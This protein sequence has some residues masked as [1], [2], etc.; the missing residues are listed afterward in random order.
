MGWF[1]NML[2]KWLGI[3]PA[4]D[5]AINLQKGTTFQQNVMRNRLWYI[6][7]PNLLSQFFKGITENTN[8]SRFWAVVPDNENEIR[9]I[10]SDIPQKAID[11]LADIVLGDLEEIQVSDNEA[12]LANSADGEARIRWD[13]IADANNFDTT[14][15]ES[16]VDILSLG[17]GAFKFIADSAFSD[18][19]IIEWIPG[20]RVDYFYKYKQLQEI[21]FFT[22]YKKGKDAY[23]LTEK[24]GKG[25]IRYELKNETNG[26]IVPLGTIAE[27]AGLADVTFLVPEIFSVAVKFKNSK[28]YTGRGAGLFDGKSDL[29]DA[30]DESLSQ[31]IDALRAGRTTQYIPQ[32]LLTPGMTPNP[33]KRRWVTVEDRLNETA[34]NV[35]Q[36]ES[37]DIKAQDYLTTHISYLDNCLQ[38]IIS[39][40]TLGIDVKKLDNAEAQREKEKTTLYMRNKI[41]ECMKKYMPELINKVL[42]LQD[43]MD[44]H[45]IGEYFCALKFGEYANPSFEA[46]V[47]TLTKA[48]PGKQIMTW[49]DIVAEMYGNDLTPEEQAAKVLKLQA[50]NSFTSANSF[51]PEFDMPTATTE[52]VTEADDGIEPTEEVTE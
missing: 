29:F 5:T 32:G 37:A 8:V 35:I 20:D 41:I 38:G 4:D 25:Y 36:T 46:L 13:D 28:D 33:I 15:T 42:K 47:E 23:T 24:Y 21:H 40:S 51:I 34:K 49:E 9:Q 1:K 27:L 12:T 16:L 14:S 7:D 45:P 43:I 6:G 11:K 10:H 18:K 39:P 48:A 52:P 30:L 31:W 19:P 26:A 17:D 22:A 50:I 44:K 3:K 2:Q